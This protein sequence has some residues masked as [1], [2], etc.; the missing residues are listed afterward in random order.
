MIKLR[1]RLGRLIDEH[2]DHEEI[3]AGFAKCCRVVLERLGWRMMR[4]GDWI[5]DSRRK[6]RA[7]PGI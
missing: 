6:I 2:L 7:E 5:A 3:A 4:K 1:S